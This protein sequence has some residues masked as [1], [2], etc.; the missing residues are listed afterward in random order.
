VPTVPISG[1]Y[2]A[3][4]GWAASLILGL[5]ILYGMLLGSIVGSTDA[6]AGIELEAPG[7]CTLDQI[8]RDRL[9][10]EPEPRDVVRVGMACLRVREMTDDRIEW[11]GLSVVDEGGGPP[12]SR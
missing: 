9:Q 11:V 8:L 2:Q 10:G 1:R 3:I 7:D 4:T 6:A 5:P 12:R